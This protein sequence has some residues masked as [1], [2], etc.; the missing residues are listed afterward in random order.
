MPT[1]SLLK[2]ALSFVVIGI[3]LALPSTAMC[4][5]A[6]DDCVRSEP[7]PVFEA[8][9]AGLRSHRFVPLSRHEAKEYVVLASGASLEVH[10]GGCEYFV[11]TFRWQSAR[12]ARHVKSRPDA[13]LA[14]AALMR[15]LRQLKQNPGF[16][17]VLA[18][19]TLETAA[20]K[21][22]KLEYEEQ[23]AVEG[24]GDDFLQAQVQLDAAGQKSGVGYIQV[25]LS[26]GP[27]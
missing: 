17:L 9:Q 10:H 19:A 8:V 26:R 24:D 21:N 27:L 16:D 22:P 14:A 25:T 5:S 2:S 15:E 6:A 12:I 3:A 11:T 13:Y 23:L 20:R 1:P 7:A 4:A 18:A